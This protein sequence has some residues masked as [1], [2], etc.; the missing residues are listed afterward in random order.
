MSD[1][2]VFMDTIVFTGIVDGIGGAASYCRLEGSLLENAKAWEGT[3]V[4][5]HMNKILKRA[6]KTSHLYKAESAEVLPK[7]FLTLRDGMINVDDVASKSIV[8]NNADTGGVV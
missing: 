1:N 7:A 8:I 2:S 5:Q 3:A 6:Y 4:G